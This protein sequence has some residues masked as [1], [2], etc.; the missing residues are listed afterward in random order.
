M[1]VLKLNNVTAISETG[2]V[3]TFGAPSSTLKYPAGHIIQIQHDTHA[4]QSTQDIGTDIDSGL[5]QA[6]TPLTGSD[7][8]VMI[9]F[10]MS[11]SANGSKDWT[12][13]IKRG[14]SVIKTYN[15]MGREDH[16]SSP[17]DSYTL[18]Y[19]DESP[20]AG[21]ANTYTFGANSNAGYIGFNWDNTPA[22]MTLFEIAG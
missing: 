3:A 8:L 13:F 21:S 10:V 18:I 19:L 6:I 16:N 9:T 1:A 7:I 15:Q 5:S 11:M 20:T 14:G 17:T 2:G 12:G 22:S 4:T